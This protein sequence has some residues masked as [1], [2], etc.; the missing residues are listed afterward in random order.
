M[1]LVL[2]HRNRG[3]AYRT[4]VSLWFPA[5]LQPPT[6]EGTPDFAVATF[7]TLIG[8]LRSA[9]LE[10]AALLV[11]LL[12][13]FAIVILLYKPANMPGISVATT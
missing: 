4:R 9:F 7:V 11:L 2:A 8:D 3:A 1:S 12:T 13:F 10:L 6:G 5:N